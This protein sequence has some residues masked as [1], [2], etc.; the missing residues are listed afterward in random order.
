MHQIQRESNPNKAKSMRICQNQRGFAMI[1][2]E[3]NDNG[4]I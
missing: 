1:Q 4:K 3:H 2:T